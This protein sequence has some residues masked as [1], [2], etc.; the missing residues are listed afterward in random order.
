MT[1]VALA[2]AQGSQQPHLRQ[3]TGPGRCP[4]AT[5]G[6]MTIGT[7]V[8]NPTPVVAT[9]GTVVRRPLHGCGDHRDRCG[10]TPPPLWRPSERLWR[11]FPGTPGPGNAKEPRHD[12]S[13]SGAPQTATQA[14]PKSPPRTT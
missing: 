4:E 6:V 13:R 2:G 9:L 1:P 5:E 14:D 7:V 3:H 12:R 10:R 11:P 8:T